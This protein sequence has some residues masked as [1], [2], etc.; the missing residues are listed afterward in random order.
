MEI[1]E[2]VDGEDHDNDTTGVEKNKKIQDWQRLAKAEIL[3]LYERKEEA[4]RQ[5][6]NL[7]TTEPHHHEEEAELEFVNEKEEQRQKILNQRNI[8]NVEGDIE[9][10]GNLGGEGNTAHLGK[11]DSNERQEYPRDQTQPKK[12]ETLAIEGENTNIYNLHGDIENIGNLGGEGNTASMGEFT[13][14]EAQERREKAERGNENIYH[15]HGAIDNIHIDNIDNFR[16]AG[17]IIPARP[18]VT[19]DVDT[20]Q[21]DGPKREET[22]IIEIENEEKEK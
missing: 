6:Y 11:Y 15:L 10:I 7:G 19:V 20:L 1:V 9:N 22:E 2:D 12:V 4:R 21:E 3:K 13:Y 18:I 17:K 8:Y 16:G 14:S 5:R